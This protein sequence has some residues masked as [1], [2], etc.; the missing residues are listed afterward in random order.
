MKLLIHLCIEVCDDGTVRQQQCSWS[1]VRDADRRGPIT[2]DEITAFS[3]DFAHASRSRHAGDHTPLNELPEVLPLE[4]GPAASQRG[5]RLEG[6]LPA[7]VRLTPAQAETLS[8]WGITPTE[9]GQITSRHGVARIA[10]I[11]KWIETKQAGGDVA[12]PK[13]LLL[14]CLRG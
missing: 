11:I 3:V 7:P 6:Q 1:I 5:Q 10:S 2:T 12:K 9:Q 4:A 13:A 8:A 14:A